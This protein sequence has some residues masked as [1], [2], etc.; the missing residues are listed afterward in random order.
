MFPSS[1]TRL[2]CSYSFKWGI[3]NCSWTIAFFRMLIVSQWKCVLQNTHFFSSS[4]NKFENVWRSWCSRI[5]SL[6]T[7]SHDPAHRHPSVAHSRACFQSAEP[8]PSL[9][10]SVISFI[11]MTFIL[12][13]HRLFSQNIKN[14][15]KF[16][17]IYQV[18]NDFLKC[19]PS[20]DL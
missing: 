16:L 3:T 15:C 18:L 8:G 14:V 12:F 20:Y 2:L 5:N 1:T 17:L 6:I 19:S 10:L 7:L 13:F 4:T 9:S 11:P